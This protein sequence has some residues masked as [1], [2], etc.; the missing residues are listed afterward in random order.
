MKYIL[1]Q[2]NRNC[3]GPTA[4]TNVLRTFGI[5]AKYKD[6]LKECGGL[7][8][9][10]K[11]GTSLNKVIKVLKKHNI[12][13]LPIHVTRKRM[14][15]FAKQPGI[16]VCLIYFWALPHKKNAKK[17][18]GGAHIVMIRRNGKAININKNSA[19]TGQRWRDTRK[20]WGFGP[21]TLV[22][23]PKPGGVR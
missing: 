5:K 12:E 14:L 1:K 7:E 4:I 10:G 19:I 20:V 9:V 22:C 3:C 13:A 6:I 2:P 21:I 11:N 23:I 18:R 17:V 15:E 16:A 8:V